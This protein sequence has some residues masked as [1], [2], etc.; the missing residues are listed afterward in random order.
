MRRL[1]AFAAGQDHRH[2][3][4]AYTKKEHWAAGLAGGS[5]AIHSTHISLV[6]QPVSPKAASG[7]YSD[8]LAVLNGTVL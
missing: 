4:R 6:V 1:P 7:R 5:Y 2:D 3:R 8:K